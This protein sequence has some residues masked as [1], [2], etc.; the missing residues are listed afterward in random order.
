LT[1]W[2][3]NFDKGEGNVKRIG[4]TIMLVVFLTGCSFGQGSKIPHKVTDG[5]DCKSCHDTGVNGAP[6]SPHPDRANCIK[7]HK[8]Q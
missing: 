2:C 8:A 3:Q 5:M 7:C 4:L 6:V 1:A